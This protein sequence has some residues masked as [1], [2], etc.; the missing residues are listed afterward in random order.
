MKRLEISVMGAL[1]CAAGGFW[2]FVELADE[3]LEGELY[4]VDRR[5][6][7][8]LRLAGDPS[9]PWGPVWVQELARDITALG[10]FG[11]LALVTAMAGGYLLLASKRHAALGLVVAVAGGQAMSLLLKMGFDRERPDFVSAATPAVTA[12]FPSG[13]TLM[14]AV[15]Y[16]TVGVLLA[17]VEANLRL[18]LYALG[19]AVFIVLLVGI[20]RVYLGVHWPS[21]VAAGWTVGAAWAAVSWLTMRWLQRRGTVEPES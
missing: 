7:L 14:A 20:S 4:D 1:A 15:T 2:L 17:G 13:H 5:L 11:V 18:K 10:S 9:R 12:S 16:L 6:L 8:A 3:L 21:D 19:C